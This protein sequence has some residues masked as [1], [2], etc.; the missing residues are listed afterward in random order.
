MTTKGRIENV[1]RSVLERELAIRKL[2]LDQSI[3]NEDP[4]FPTD[5]ILLDALEE[6][7]NTT[8]S[9]VYTSWTGTLRHLIEIV[10][11]NLEK[12]SD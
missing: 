10:E 4:D 6:L 1:L 3:L 12:R 2:E 5:E 8:S 11:A 9:L 7:G